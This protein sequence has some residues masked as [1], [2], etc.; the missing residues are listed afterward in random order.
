LALEASK[1][2]KFKYTSSVIT[3]NF[4]FFFLKI[5]DQGKSESIKKVGI[6]RRCP[7]VAFGRASKDV[8][9]PSSYLK[10]TKEKKRK[11]KPFLVKVVCMGN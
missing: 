4:F 8:V 1:T 6:H 11:R 2:P 10:T 7:F 9:A 5:T 3:K